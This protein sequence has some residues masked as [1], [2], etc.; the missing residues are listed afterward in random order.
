[1][2]SL[3]RCAAAL[4]IAATAFPLATVA[5]SAAPPATN[6]G[7]VVPLKNVLRRCDFS[8]VFVS[9]QMAAADASVSSIVRAGGGTVSADVHLSNPSSPGTHYDVKLIQ[10]PQA[11]QSLCG[12]GDPGVAV[13]S[14][15]SDG[16]GQASTTVQG[17]IRSG[18]TGAWVLVQRPGQ[19]A[20]DPSEFYSSDFVAP[21]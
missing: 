21:V 14:L 9:P 3:M 17:S 18:T 4:A 1:M 7:T 16:A 11:S 19:F 6:G 10:A 12:P 2:S 8:P 13:G 5:A 20:Q 15:D